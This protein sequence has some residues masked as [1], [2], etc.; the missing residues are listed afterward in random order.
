MNSSVLIHMVDVDENYSKL[1]KSILV[2]HNFKH[3]TL[4]TNETNCLAQMIKKPK[5]LITGYH[6][7]NMS[8]L[9]LIKKARAVYPNFYSILLSG[10]FHKD[11]QNVYDER[12]LQYVDKY[13]IKGMDDME[14]LIE[15]VVYNFA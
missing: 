3:V 15:A 4:F 12:F 14:D 6:L 10:D 8:G 7:K 11:T 1:V 13:I 9:Q 5:I 2:K